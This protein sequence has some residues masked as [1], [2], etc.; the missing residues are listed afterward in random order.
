MQVTEVR[1]TPFSDGGRL[2]AYASI[3]IGGSFA[4]RDIRVVEGPGGMIVAMPSKK[5]KDGSYKDVAFPV[6]RGAR[7]MV[8]R[9]VIEEYRRVAA[10]GP[11]RRPRA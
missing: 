8:E 6:T 9:A 10:K 1:V 7:E 4:I 2:R 3:T 5:L 11:A